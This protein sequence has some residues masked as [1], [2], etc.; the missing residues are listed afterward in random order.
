LNLLEKEGSAGVAKRQ[1]TTLSGHGV[2]VEQSPVVDMGELRKAARALVLQVAD[3]AEVPIEALHN[4]AA[5]TLRCELVQLAQRLLDAPPEFA[6]RRAMEL[7]GLV[8]TSGTKPRAADGP[9]HVD[10]AGAGPT[11]DCDVVEGKGSTK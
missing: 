8:L 6:I 10:E 3:G 1:Q 4:F 5:L 7:A 11:P 9:S 2:P